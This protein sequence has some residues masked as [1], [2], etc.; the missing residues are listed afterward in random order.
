MA[1]R[2]GFMIY[3]DFAPALAKLTDDEAGKLFKAIMDYA[4]MGI[5]SE[6]EGLCGFAFEMIRPRIDKDR[7][8]Y[9]EKCRKSSYTAYVREAKKRGETFLEYGEWLAQKASVH[10]RAQSCTDVHDGEH[11]TLPEPKEEQPQG[12]VDNA[13]PSDPV[14]A[15]LSDYLNRINP[16]ASPT[17]LDE[18]RSYAED[19]GED[20]C[21]RAFDLAIDSKKTTWPYIK[22]IL[23]DKLKRGVKCLADWDAQE[24][25]RRTKGGKMN[26]GNT[27]DPGQS[28]RIGKRV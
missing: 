23:Q 8:V 27:G 1:E 2:P 11:P 9:E 26:G 15:V 25:A 19:L 28:A 6:I 5:V 20:V 21:K 12:H 7:K 4:S 3:F 17:S 13:S 16:T 14:A 24:E 10:D 22:A 18:L